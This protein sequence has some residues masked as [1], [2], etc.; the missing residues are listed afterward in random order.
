MR[1]SSIHADGEIRYDACFQFA[2]FRADYVNLMTTLMQPG[3]IEHMAPRPPSM[4][5]LHTRYD[6]DIPRPRLVTRFAY[7]LAC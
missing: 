5:R 2:A 3:T 1:G 6:L 7:L 4:G